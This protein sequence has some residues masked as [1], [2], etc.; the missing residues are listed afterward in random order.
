MHCIYANPHAEK[1]F[2][3]CIAVAFQIYVHNFHKEVR[4]NSWK[5]WIWWLEGQWDSFIFRSRRA[6]GPNN[7]VLQVLFHR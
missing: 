4:P 3:Q 7:W 2:R 5:N 1:N 6:V